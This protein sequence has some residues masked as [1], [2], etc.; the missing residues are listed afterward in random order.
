MITTS[1]L[2]VVLLHSGNAV[3]LD[4]RMIGFSF[5]RVSSDDRNDPLR[6]FKRRD[7]SAMKTQEEMSNW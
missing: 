7:S 3:E 1:H 5:L 4:H 6:S 2:K